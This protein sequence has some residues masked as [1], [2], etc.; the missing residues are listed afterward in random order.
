[1]NSVLSWVFGNAV[2]CIVFGTI[3]IAG[4][5]LLA[6][7][8][9]NLHTSKEIR[10]SLEQSRLDQLEM[11]RQ[12]IIKTVCLEVV[13]NIIRMKDKKFTETDKK[14]L[15]EY[16]VFPRMSTAALSSALESAL[17]LGKQHREF[18]D[19]VNM[20]LGRLTD[21][22]HRLDITDEELRKGTPEQISSFRKKL[23]DGKLFDDRKNELEQFTRDM[24]SQY[25]D[26]L[27]DWFAS[28][29]TGEEK[30]YVEKLRKQK[31]KT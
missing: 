18:F 23:R 17:F 2:L 6:T 25:E 8:G 7:H 12:G 27:V 30:A 21:L 10:A 28:E 13:T 5:G 15:S 14:K 29:L 16:V 4:G 31:K 20:L 11:K 26:L 9:W 19:A 24:L 22:N 1:M 3:L